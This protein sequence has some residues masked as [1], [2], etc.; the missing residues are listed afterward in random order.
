MMKEWV[1]GL[2]GPFPT[3]LLRGMPT[4]R[5]TMYGDLGEEGRWGKGPLSIPSSKS[6]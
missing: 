4:L 3:A 1:G 2:E 5:Q 6:H